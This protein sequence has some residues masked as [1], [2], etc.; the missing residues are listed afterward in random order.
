MLAPAHGPSVAAG[1]RCQRC[2]DAR[3]SAQP[4]TTAS[5]SLFITLS[6]GSSGASLERAA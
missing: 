2:N 3:V 6:I 5:C 4:R 1:A